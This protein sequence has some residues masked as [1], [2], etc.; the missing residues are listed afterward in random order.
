MDNLLPIDTNEVIEVVE[1]LP[2]NEILN[3]IYTSL[4]N[5]EYSLQILAGFG[6]FFIVVALCYFCYKFFRIFI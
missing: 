5:V 4:Q 3:Q 1:G 6:L 2:Y